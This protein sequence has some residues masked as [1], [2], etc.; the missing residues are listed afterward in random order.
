[1]FISV[2]SLD[3]ARNPKDGYP[4][5]KWLGRVE[6]AE[7]SRQTRSVQGIVITPKDGTITQA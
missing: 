4:K 7:S 3:S 2:L 1:M 6:T 5:Q